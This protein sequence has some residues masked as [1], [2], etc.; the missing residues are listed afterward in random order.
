MISMLLKWH[1]VGVFKTDMELT[2]TSDKNLTNFE[3]IK[4]NQL[5]KRLWIDERTYEELYTFWHIFLCFDIVFITSWDRNFPN[6]NWN[7]WFNALT[8][9]SLVTPISINKLGHI[10]TANDLMLVYFQAITWSNAD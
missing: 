2:S 5:Q 9:W 10:G 8:R 3:K 6:D 4:K 7:K 1:V